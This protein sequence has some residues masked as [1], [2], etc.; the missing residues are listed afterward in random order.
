MLRR[1]LADKEDLADLETRNEHHISARDVERALLTLI[2]GLKDWRLCSLC[3]N[4][5]GDWY[6]AL[7]HR[8]A[9]EW[10]Q[11][12]FVACQHQTLSGALDRALQK[13]VDKQ[14]LISAT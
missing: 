3:E 11:K 7:E 1:A 14:A 5:S 8:S 9:V 6:V 12:H 4:A 10:Q 2:A 13:A